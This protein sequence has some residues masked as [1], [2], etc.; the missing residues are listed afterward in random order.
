MKKLIIILLLNF[1]IIGC[2]DKKQQYVNDLNSY[3]NTAERLRTISGLIIADSRST[4]EHP[5]FFNEDYRVQSINLNKTI[6]S[7]YMVLLECPA[8]FQ[9][10]LHDIK[11][12]YQNLKKSETKVN[13]V[14]S[15]DYSWRDDMWFKNNDSL[16]VYSDRIEN[17][18]YNLK[19]DIPQAF[20][21]DS[22]DL[23]E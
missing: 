14:F 9:T 6:D 2:A 22:T 17:C 18:I 10:S 1:I 7:L 23:K 8:D 20:L 21:K 4:K 15:N 5:S 16:T 3:V 12:I 13:A 11:T 19:T